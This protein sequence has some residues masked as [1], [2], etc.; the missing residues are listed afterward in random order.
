MH[1]LWIFDMIFISNI[2]L[3][4]FIF[5]FIWAMK[6]AKPETKKKKVKFAFLV[7]TLQWVSLSDYLYTVN[8]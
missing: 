6:D 8:G 5:I 3:E 2:L 1:N 7:R 4:I